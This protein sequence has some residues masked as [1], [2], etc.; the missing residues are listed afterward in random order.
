MRGGRDKKP[1][2]QNGWQRGMEY[3][4]FPAFLFIFFFNS[5][6]KVSIMF[7]TNIANIL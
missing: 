3:V 2:S 5:R 6:G 1:G 4:S 7:L